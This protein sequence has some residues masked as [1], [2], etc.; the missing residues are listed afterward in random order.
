M[1]LRDSYVLAARTIT[2]KYRGAGTSS[3]AAGGGRLRARASGDHSAFLD[4]LG[5]IDP[6]A[7]RLYANWGPG[8]PRRTE[9]VLNRRSDWTFPEGRLSIILWSWRTRT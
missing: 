8:D 1:F 3:D 6:S 2:P 9:L 7:S 5:R 4:P